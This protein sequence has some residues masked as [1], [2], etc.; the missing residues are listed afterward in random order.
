MWLGVFIYLQAKVW[1]QSNLI[2]MGQITLVIVDG[3][4]TQSVNQFSQ[5]AT[6][7]RTT[8]VNSCHPFTRLWIGSKKRGREQATKFVMTPNFV[9]CD[10]RTTIHSMFGRLTSFRFWTVTAVPFHIWTPR[11]LR[12]YKH[13]WSGAREWENRAFL[14]FTKYNNIMFSIFKLVFEYCVGVW[15]DAPKLDWRQVTTFDTSQQCPI[16]LL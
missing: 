3:H 4:F 14:R 15:G 10:R 1:I 16:L 12:E 11:R 7:F 8:I 13:P 6:F 5:V 9:H 2:L